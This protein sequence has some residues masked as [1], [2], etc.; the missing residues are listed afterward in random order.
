MFS[1]NCKIFAINT[2]ICLVQWLVAHTKS[3]FL[4]AITQKYKK[5]S[6]ASFSEKSV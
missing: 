3:T 5:T 6:S 4:L 1:G 2:A